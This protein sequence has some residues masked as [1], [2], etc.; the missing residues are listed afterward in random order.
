MGST[1]SAELPLHRLIAQAKL[2]H[3]N[4]HAGSPIDYKVL[5][6]L[7]TRIGRVHH[8]LGDAVFYEPKTQSLSLA[9]LE[10]HLKLR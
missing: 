7:E 6:E 4:A 10:R 1:I 5:T 9:S 3:M 2:M 8:Q